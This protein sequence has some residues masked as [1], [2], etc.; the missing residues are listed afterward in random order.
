M[1][2]AMMRGCVA[3]LAIV[4]LAGCDVLFGLQAIPDASGDGLAGDG[5][6][7]LYGPA[8]GGLLRVCLDSGLDLSWQP[9]LS[10]D[11][12]SDDCMQ[13][14]DQ[15]NG[16]QL[17]VL[18]GRSIAIGAGLVATGSRPLVLVA[19]EDLLIGAQG[20]I[21]VDGRNALAP[22]PGANDA[23]CSAMNVDG[24]RSNLAGGG[25]GGAGG[26]FATRGGNGGPPNATDARGGVAAEP[27]MVLGQIR[28]GCP[29]GKG[30]GTIAT[31]SVSGGAVYLIAGRSI[32]IEGTIDASGGGGPGGVRRMELIAHGGGGG[33]S[34]GLIALDAPSVMLSASA[35]LAANGGGGGGGAVDVVDGYAGQAAQLSMD[36]F[37]APGGNG[38]TAAAGS[39]GSGEDR[40]GVAG[41]GA[42]A[43]EN[44]A[45][46]GGGGGGGGFIRVYT[47]AFTNDAGSRV[48]PKL[49]Q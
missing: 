3:G 8:N 14:V 40:N 22:G 6:Y 12:S 18:A 26:S 16:P 35:R 34:G 46:G 4:L 17:C 41:P 11:T 38:A 5:C 9:R 27:V 15:P 31:R 49:V 25:G 1:M 45:G 29:G 19:T 13:V 39:G 43:V 47:T 36:G 32:T 28:G 33:G 7:G 44:I 23:T 42:Q 2:A 10:I 37:P 24:T 48:S 21:S 20:H 30:T